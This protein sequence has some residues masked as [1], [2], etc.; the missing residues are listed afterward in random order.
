[1][2][3]AMTQ[4]WSSIG[5][6]FL[7]SGAAFG[8][9]GTT[10]SETSTPA[11]EAADVHVSPKVRLPSMASGGLRGTRYL[12][13][14]GTIVD[15]IS[16]AY[17][18]DN[19]KILGGPSWLDLDRFDLSARAPEGSKP[20]QAKLMLQTLLAQRFG[21]TLHKDSKELPGLVLSP[22]SGKTKMKPAADAAASANCQ[23]QPQTASPD[24]V[25]QQVVDCHSISVED[26]ARL[27]ANFANASGS[28]VNK[29]GLEGKWDFTIKWTPAELLARAG[30]DGIS[31]FDA[32]D[33]QL[34]LKLERGKVAQPVILVDSVNRAPTPNAA[35]IAKFMP[36]PP[37]VEFDVALIKPT[38]PDF[39]G[40]RMQMQGNQIN[41]QGATLNML[42][43]QFYDVT[44]E[45]MQGAP[46]FM[47]E[48][49]W[50]I[51]AKMVSTD[52][53]QPAQGDPATRTKLMIKL[54]EDRFQLK[55]HFEDRVVPAYTLSSVKP[56]MAKA[57]PTTRTGCY[58]GPGPDGKDPRIANPLLSRLLYCRNMTMAQFADQ[59]PQQ[60]DGY[61]HT[62]VLDKTGLTDAYDFTVSFSDLAIL[63]DSLKGAGQPGGAADPNGALSLSDAISKQLGLKLELE[64]RPASVLVIDHMEQMP[65]E[66]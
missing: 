24:T 26:L 16:L 66:N 60:G 14:Q 59:L 35:D 19:D 17:D 33:K 5:L 45:M 12:V 34:G 62:A 39:K 31:I 9:A 63:Q 40:A 28:A 61:V 8:Q 13:R 7:L 64:K 54:L 20:E 10:A 4:V 36:P 52:P 38:N 44:P 46:K 56:K 30:A 21:L 32:V 27:I 18:V 22:G 50:D 49:R 1:M 48:D 57:D 29:T 51:T 55:M 6:A 2:T 43:Q 65:T 11:F 42:L 23:G 25:P 47:D 58:E 41:I 15:L 37:A 53:G 3:Q